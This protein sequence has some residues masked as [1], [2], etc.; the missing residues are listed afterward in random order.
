MSTSDLYLL[1]KKGTTHLL[2]MRNGWGSGPV[3]WDYLRSKY[4]TE[5]DP[6]YKK[7]WK[8]AG[9]PR[10]AIHE[11]IA[12]MITFDK[13][14]VPKDKL[15]EAAEACRQIYAE[16]NSHQQVNHWLS[17]ADGLQFAAERKLSRHCRG[18]VLQCTSVSDCWSYP[19]K[20]WLENA[21]SIFADT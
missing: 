18:V 3:I 14:Y 19:S 9:D 8:L 6:S 7:T 10:V 12:L 21:W 11:K 13:A 5:P 15:A 20:D 17:I 4:I 2:E 1:N 16:M